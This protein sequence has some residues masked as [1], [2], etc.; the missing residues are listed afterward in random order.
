MSILS[1]GAFLKSFSISSVS[2]KKIFFEVLSV[3]F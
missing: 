3:Y 2:L 1:G